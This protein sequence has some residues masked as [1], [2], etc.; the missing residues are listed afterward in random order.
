MRGSPQHPPFPPLIVILFGIL[1]ISTASIFIRYAQEYAPSLVIAAYRLTLAT[2]VLAP[3]ALSRH[4]IELLALTRRERILTVLSGLFLAIH[5]ATWITSLAYTTVASSVILVS[6]SPL[7]VALLSPLTIK[8]SISRSVLIGVFLA[9]A[10]GVVVGISDAC[11]WTNEQ[12]ACPPIADLMRGQAFLGNILALMGAWAGAGYLL[13]GRRL[14][15]K[16]TLVSYIFLVYGV[17]AVILVAT[18]FLAGYLP[19]GFPAPVYLWLLLLALIPQ[20]LGH[21]SLNWALRYLSAA[22][23]SITLLSEPVGST[24]LAYI[25]LDEKPTSLMIFGA[26][27]ILTG[28]YIATQSEMQVKGKKEG[29]VRVE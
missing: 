22:Y 21:S 16:M 17:A 18:M 3:F 1:A 13:I 4:R 10:G 15:V 20:L 26:I 25:L 2:L 29:K 24:I 12:L 14:R 8:E 5:F 6:T 11:I 28:I 9:L 19:W 27:L 7:W 23:V